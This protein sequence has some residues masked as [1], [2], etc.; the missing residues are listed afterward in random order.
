MIF[1][2]AKRWGI[3][4]MRHRKTVRGLALAV[5]ALALFGPMTSQLTAQTAEIPQRIERIHWDSGDHY[6]QG[7]AFD[8]GTEPAKLV[9]SDIL[10]VPNVP[11]M[12][13][14]FDRGDLGNKSR[15]EITSLL[16]RST[17]ILDPKSFQEWGGRSA[18][19]N[20]DA[21]EIR[22]FVGPQDQGVHV[23]VREV[24]VGEWGPPPEKSICGPSDNR[25]DSTDSRVGRIDPIGC[26]GWMVD[27]GKLLTAGH[28]L[29]GSGNTTLS[30]LPPKSLS[31]G[32]VQFPPAD[33]QYSIIQ[34]SFD[35]VDGGVGND[36]G[37]FAVNDNSVTGL[38]PGAAHGSFAIRQDFGPSTIRITGFGTDSGIDN[39]SLQTH[40]GSNTGSSGTTMRYNADT[41]GGNSGSPVIDEATNE[42]V[43]IHTHGGCSSS[44]GN[45]SGTSFFNSALWTAVNSGGGGGPGDPNCAGG[46]LDLSSL[47]FTSYSNQNSTND[48]TVQDNGDTI[49]LVGNTWVRTTQS[50]NITANTVIDFKVASG[51]Q[52]EI[53][54]IGFDNNDTLNDNP[55]HF[56]FWGTQ[57]W[58]GT[59]KIDLTPKYSGAGAY[60]SY[61]VP[62]GQSYTGTMFLVLTN[63]KDSGAANNEGYFACINIREE[64]GGS[65]DVEESFETSAGGW[66]TSGNC[67]TGTFVRGTPDGV[68]NGGVQTQVSGAQ[69]G[70]QALFTASNA[71]GAGADDVDQGECVVTSPVY[72][73]T[74]AS[75]VSAWYFHGQRDAGDDASGDYFH[76]EASVNGGSW[77]SLQSYGDV[78]VNAAW[79]EATTTVN[80]GDSVRLRVRTSDGSAAGDLV[81]AGIDNVSIC[82]Q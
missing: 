18:Y 36:W 20:G 5:L 4:E 81:E 73:V 63:D 1:R 67:A 78:T 26:T 3:A 72:N 80:A 66:T 53:H 76:L 7:D 10:S 35:F 70:S 41:T 79:T 2:Q 43:G 57:N 59:G 51:N 60:Q 24:V 75:N 11:W 62:V 30:I 28:C 32:T 23:G 12:Q 58:T 74:A 27:N 71:G 68:T 21:V 77:Q 13:L 38:Q 61:S 49:K 65:C 39:Q 14:I 44:G 47:N 52:G 50:F 54:A 46:T 55:R 22:F 64:G 34:S 8:D 17:Q 19:F 45:N 6:G 40:S 33:R 37:V 31:N 25:V 56:Q 82:P 69:D 9:V 16:D 42:A 29:D 48:A 15:I